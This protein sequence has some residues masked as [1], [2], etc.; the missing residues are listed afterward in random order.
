[1][2]INNVLELKKE[3]TEIG[4]RVTLEDFV[5]I[6]KRVIPH[7]S[8]TETSLVTRL[9]NLFAEIDVDNDGEMTWDE[10]TSFVIKSGVHGPDSS[11]DLK[12]YCEIIPKKEI[13]VQGAV[14]LK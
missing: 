3:F 7:R 12:E 5:R 6:V 11:M 2:E 14:K 4:G 13:P 8:E 1:M 10:F 9:A